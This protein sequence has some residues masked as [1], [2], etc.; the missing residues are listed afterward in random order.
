[1]SFLFEVVR[2]LTDLA[3]WRGSDGIPARLAEQAA[4]SGASVLVAC[5]VAVPVGLVLG[6]RRK[7]VALA[8]NVSNVGRAVPSFAL[9]VLAAE[10]FGIGAAPA[11]VALVA[12]AIPPLVTGSCVGVQSVEAEVVEAASGMGMSGRQL[13]WRV[14]LPVALPQVLGAVRTTTVQVV[15]TASLAAV[16]AWGG[17]GRFVI[18][19]L[20]RRDFAMATA[21]ALL[22]AL[23]AM[24]TE[25]LLGGITRR[26]VPVGVQAGAAG[27]NA[28]AP[29]T[30]Q[31][32]R[33]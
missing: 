23:L 9:L 5:L 25:V 11:F 12:L 13:L 8:V 16:V 28:S 20:A 7:G 1:V 2:W 26:L 22:V 32:S 10:V 33:P 21:G 27:Q 18:D 3:H 6:H 17:L 14:E 29:T 30:R 24:G 15:A 31:G 4:M 19:G